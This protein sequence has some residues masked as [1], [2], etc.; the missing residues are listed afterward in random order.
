MVKTLAI[1]SRLRPASLLNAGRIDIYI[2]A[3]RQKL[4]T[5]WYYRSSAC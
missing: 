5:R 1:P 4:V 3:S 2:Y